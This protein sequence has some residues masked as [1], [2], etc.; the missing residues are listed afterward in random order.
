MNG[1]FLK[2]WAFSNPLVASIDE[3]QR[4]LSPMFV[5]DEPSEPELPAGSTSGGGA[6]FGIGC[7]VLLVTVWIV[8]WRM[9]RSDRKFAEK[10][11]GPRFAQE[12]TPRF[13]DLDVPPPNP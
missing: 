10:T 6:L 13:D 4:Q 8:V 2:L 9:N 7:L 3:R 1:V 12:P 11:R 5:V